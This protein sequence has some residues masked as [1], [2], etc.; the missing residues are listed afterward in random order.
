MNSRYFLIISAF[1]SILNSLV[2]WFWFEY[3]CFGRFDSSYLVT[4][5]SIDGPFIDV[6][7]TPNDVEKTKLL[8]ELFWHPED[9][10]IGFDVL[11]YLNVD[12][13]IIEKRVMYN[14]IHG[15]GKEKNRYI[16]HMA[17]DY[18]GFGNQVSSLVG[19]IALALATGRRFR[20]IV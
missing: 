2:H 15:Y 5:Q 6:E 11:T 10:I 16:I 18:S 9:I 8:N 7:L 4:K 3:G 17:R 20:S 1:I 19:N 13:G 14:L 12:Y